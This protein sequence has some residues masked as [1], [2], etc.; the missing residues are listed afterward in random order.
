MEAFPS[1]K[2]THATPEPDATPD[3]MPLVSWGA[4]ANDKLT[5]CLKSREYDKFVA[6][7]KKASPVELF[8]AQLEISAGVGIL[9]SR[10]TRLRYSQ[11]VFHEIQSRLPRK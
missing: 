3:P 10:E 8:R 9:F 7:T 5:R 1:I 4:T 11:A 2:L 6:Q